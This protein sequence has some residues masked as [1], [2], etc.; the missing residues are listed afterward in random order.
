MSDGG[1]WVVRPFSPAVWPAML[2]RVDAAVTRAVPASPGWVASPGRDPTTHRRPPCH[3]S[4]PRCHRLP[5]RRRPR[6]GPGRPQRRA[7]RV[8]ARPQPLRALAHVG[9]HRR[10]RARRVPHLPPV[11]VAPALGRRPRGGPGRRHR[12]ASRAPRPRHLPDADPRC[13]RGDARRGRRPGLQHPQRP[14]PARVPHHGLAGRRDRA[15]RGRGPLPPGGGPDAA[16]PGAGREVVARH[17]VRGARP[18]RSS[19]TPPPSP[20]CCRACPRPGAGG[21]TGHPSSCGGGTPRARSA[22]G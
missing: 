2:P 18:T 6:M 21:P 1:E 17:H 22:T 12:D 8:E 11:A 19:P 10:R 5:R 14:E 15:R 13:G 4:R 20:R 3:G 16:R 9:G 7:V